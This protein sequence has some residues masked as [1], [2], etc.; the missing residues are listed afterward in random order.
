MNRDNTGE[1][2]SDKECMIWQKER[3]IQKR[4]KERERSVQGQ[5]NECNGRKQQIS[6]SSSFLAMD[7]IEYRDPSAQ[8]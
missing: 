1:L 2:H 3:I 4:D 7:E 6:I 5:G 8:W